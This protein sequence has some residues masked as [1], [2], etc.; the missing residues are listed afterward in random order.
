MASTSHL[1]FA[2]PI[3]GQI[4]EEEDRYYDGNDSL[5]RC[6]SPQGICSLSSATPA[7]ATVVVNSEHLLGESNYSH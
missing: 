5:P 7:A 1:L 4:K 6:Q 2:Q 3:S